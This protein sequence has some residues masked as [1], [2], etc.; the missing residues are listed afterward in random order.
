MRSEAEVQS[1][2]VPGLWLLSVRQSTTGV[3]HIMAGPPLDISLHFTSLH[4]TFSSLAHFLLLSHA[5][6]HGPAYYMPVL[7]EEQL[8][9][10]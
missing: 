8:E 2:S 5:H 1:P 3:I 6:A 9:R 7:Q 4:F 10:R